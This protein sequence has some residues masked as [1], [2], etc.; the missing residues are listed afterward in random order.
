VKRHETPGEVAVALARHAPKSIRALLDPAVGTGNLIRPLLSR[1]RASQSKVVCVDI[2]PEAI[3]YVS[4]SYR[5][6][7][8]SDAKFIN[9]DFLTWEAADGFEGFDCIVMNPPFAAKKSCWQLME[10]AHDDGEAIAR[11]TPLE[12]AFLRKSI[13]LL[14]DGGRLL[15]I[16]PCSV[17]MADSLQWLRDKML[18]D[19]A[20][21]FVHELPP[22]TFANVESRMYLLVFEK[23]ASRRTINLL[24]HDLHKPER[25]TLQLADGRSERLDFGFV[26]ACVKLSKL[27]RRRNLQWTP[28]SD[29]A[30]VIRGEIDSPMG[31]RCAIHSTDYSGGFWH[32]SERHDHAIGEKLERRIRRGDLLMSRVGRAASRSVGRGI[33]ITGMAC[34]D[35]VL[36]IRPKNY[37]TSL[38]ILFALRFVLCPEWIQPLVERGTGATYVSHK[39]LLDLRIP[40]DLWKRYPAQFR[41][42]VNAERSRNAHLASEAIRAVSGQI[43]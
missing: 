21:R 20:I 35:C 8:G 32:A 26:S 22:R 17:V 37:R 34:S 15:S 27:Q 39:S 11:P 18:S 28:L 43:K 30:D 24:N 7:L 19:G 42:F 3:R 23:G 40:A 1:V 5:S 10:T 36:I 38:K 4:D 25:I 31:P 33:G 2:D 6:E 14:R 9:A 13:D 41:K 12:A 29:V 16:L